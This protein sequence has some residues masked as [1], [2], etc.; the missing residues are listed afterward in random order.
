MYLTRRCRLKNLG[1]MEKI[2]MRPFFIYIGFIKITFRLH[3]KGDSIHHSKTHLKHTCFANGDSI[4]W[5]SKRTIRKTPFAGCISLPESLPKTGK[6][7]SVRLSGLHPEWTILPMKASGPFIGDKIQRLY[8]PSTPH[9]LLPLHGKALR[10]QKQ[11]MITNIGRLEQAICPS[12]FQHHSV[13]KNLFVCINV[14]KFPAVAIRFFLTVHQVYFPVPH[15][16]CIMA[17]CFNAEGFRILISV[18]H[19]RGIDTDVP[20][21]PVV[22]QKKGIP[23]HDTLYMVRI[24]GL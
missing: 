5:R 7:N 24:H 3:R 21:K 12:L 8:F 18:W 13:N 23:V 15:K 2:S 6:D 22:I 10:F 14:S 1:L 20:H 4:R 9:T 17:F 16:S 19:L 11:I